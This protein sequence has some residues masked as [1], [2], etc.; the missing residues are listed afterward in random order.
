MFCQCLKVLN[1]NAATGFIIVAV[2]LNT[3][4]VYIIFNNSHQT[5]HTR[6][7]MFVICQRQ[8]KK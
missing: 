6:L 8:R 1:V 7:Q 2:N 3:E 4:N 5:S